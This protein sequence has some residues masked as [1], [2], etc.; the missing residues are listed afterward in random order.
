MA[1]CVCVYV[2]AEAYFIF[3]QSYLLA[4]KT[5]KT[6]NRK[7]N[8]THRTVPTTH[9]QVELY[10]LKLVVISVDIYGHYLLARLSFGLFGLDGFSK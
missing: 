9:R 10:F 5:V 1:A 7:N 4:K 3:V 8:K 2:K 6:Q